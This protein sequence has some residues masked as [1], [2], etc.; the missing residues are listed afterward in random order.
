MKP[1]MKWTAAAVV[2]TLLAAG[3]VR[4]LSARKEK[5]L[6]L[7]A[8]QLA[9]KTQVSIELAAADL[10]Q[11]KTITL[12]QTLAISG[13]VTAV[14]IALVKARVA[15]EL[16]GLAVR[17]GDHV[18][19]GQV[20]AEIDPTESDARVRQA[21]QQAAAAKAQVDSAQRS[22]SNNQSLVAQGFISN[23]AL[24]SSQAN[25]ATAQANYA[26]AQ[27]GADI[28]AKTLAD[29]VLRAPIAGQISQRL[30]QP[31]ERVAVDARVLEIVDNRQLELE[32]SLNAADAMQVKVGQNAELQLDGLTQAVSAKLVRINPSA[33]PGSRTVRIYLALAPN[34]QLRHGLFA[35]GKLNLGAITT[36]ALPLSAVRTD[37]PQPYVQVVSKGQVQHVPVTIG[38]RGTFQNQALVAVTG[39][40]EGSTVIDGSVGAM[41][42]GTLVKSAT[43]VEPK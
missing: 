26:A 42:D 31:G 7:E 36:L 18:N 41:R 13:S 24:E 23:T 8:Q 34:S 16:R 32:V 14:R 15:G 6:A 12:A 21:R 10:V 30:A 39:L 33:A 38:Q 20:L 40:P 4:T 35:Q 19:A 28:A 3:A 5:Q 43:G 37:K 17:E 25:L 27:S 29:T 9:A 1:W 22:F 11:A 2:A